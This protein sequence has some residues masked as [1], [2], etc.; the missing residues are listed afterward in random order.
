MAKKK[1]SPI[2]AV[3]F[4]ILAPGLGQIYNGELNKGIKYYSIVLL[5]SIL[6]SILGLYFYGFIILLIIAI[7]WFIF[8]IF[9]SIV[10]ANKVK[11]IELHNYNKWYIY[12]IFLL[13]IHFISL[14]P[15]NLLL[16]FKA[17]SVASSAMEHTLLIGDYLMVNKSAYW[18]RNP[19][20]NKVLISIGKPRRGDVAVFIFPR[21]PARIISNGSSA[22]PATG[23]RS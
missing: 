12:V 13:L 10:T 2:I 23:S 19:F 20:S 6:G 7:S 21:T 9:D 4:S 3:I 17:Y 14:L 18:V 22:Y 16:S 11:E 5:I 15:K 8:I 1:R